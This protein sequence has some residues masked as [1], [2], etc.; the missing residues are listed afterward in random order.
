MKPDDIDDRI[1]KRFLIEIKMT[2]KLGT[3]FSYVK[4]L[5]RMLR[6]LGKEELAEKLKYPKQP[7]KAPDLPSP[8][9]VE[10][11]IAGFR[12]PF[13]TIAAIIYET[14]ARVSEVL[15]LKYKHIKETPQG[16][17]RKILE[18]PKNKES[19]TTYVIKYAVLLRNY[20]LHPGK[21]DKTVFKSP[22]HP[23]KPLNPRNVELA[24]RKASRKHNTRIYPHLLRHLRATLLIKQGMSN[25]RNY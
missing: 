18:E 11:I 1:L 17:Y 13:K 14:R 20:L 19:R 21:P 16:Y 2:R 4:V 6:V 24:L 8:E 5:K 3:V 15:S 23:E 9:L 7:E 10:K 22:V 25:R 12:D